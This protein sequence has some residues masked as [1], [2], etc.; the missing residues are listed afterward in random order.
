MEKRK[1]LKKKSSAAMAPKKSVKR[2]SKIKSFG[3]IT[4]LVLGVVLIPSGFVLANYIQGRIDEGVADQ[5][6]VPHPHNSEFEEWES[7]NYEDAPEQYKT[8]Y[9]WNLTN[10][11]EYLQGAT[12]VFE[13][14]GPFVFRMYKY[15]YD[16]RF[17]E[18]KNEV[19]YKEYIDYIQVGGEKISE[20]M[21]TNINPGFLGSVI[22]AGGDTPQLTELMLPILLS[23]V[24]TTFIAELNAIMKDLL[25]PAGMK[26]M[27]SESIT[28]QIKS[29]L[30]SLP[31]NI[32]NLLNWFFDFMN[33]DL[34]EITNA[35]IEASAFIIPIDQVVS[36]M[37]AAMPTA[38][39]ILYEEWANDYYPPVTVNLST[40]ISYLRENLDAEDLYN[41]CDALS[42]QLEDGLFKTI[43][44]W[45]MYIID[46]YD[47]L[48]DD[49]IDLT[50]GLVAKY[51]DVLL[52]LLEGLIGDMV[53]D[54]GAGLVDKNGGPAGVGVDIDG[55][56]PYNFPGAPAD[57][58]ISMHS[59]GGSG[60]TLE[61]SKAL[62]D[63]SDPLSLTGFN[64]R[65]NKIW[66]KALA[67]DSESKTE[68]ISHFG[69]T[70]K[71]LN[72]ILKWINVGV[73]TW[74]K[75]AGGW[76]LNDWNSDLIVTR[77]AEEVLFTGIDTAV[78]KAQ[79]YYGLDLS[80][81]E[82]NI[83]DDC[84]NVEEAEAAETPEITQKTG[85]HDASEVGEI[86][87]Y[88]DQ[89]EITIWA[90]PIDVKGTDGT[91]FGP[92]VTDEDTLK[93]FTKD[94][95][96]TVEFEYHDEAEIYD[97]D[98]LEFKFADDTFAPNS[99]YLMD[100]LGLVNLAPVPKYRDVPVRVS[101]P[102]FLGADPE[103]TQDVEGMN[104]DPALHDTYLE[105]EPITGLTM[106]VRQRIQVNL[107]PMQLTDWSNNAPHAVMPLLWMEDSGQVSEELATYFKEQVYG[108]MELK[109]QV[110]IY[111][112][113]IGACLAV[114]GAGFKTTQT[115]RKRQF[116]DKVLPKKDKLAKP[117][118]GDLIDRLGIGA[119][120]LN[121]GIHKPN[122]DNK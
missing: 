65:E 14:V 82:V 88:N 22:E 121:N 87:D 5:V 109:E 102:H 8:I 54:I 60:I 122:G 26:A 63:K 46:H 7:N 108:A 24:R 56:A 74:A 120:G 89:D 28:S 51:E 99:I 41:F 94:L 45:A 61:Q 49:I 69:I 104:P 6:K 31:K 76:T 15:K 48:V 73:N 75:N 118:V 9:L 95:M 77:S 33:I 97:I 85:R 84:Q 59:R 37:K 62:W 43:L 27:L 96:R 93:V 70:V 80:L 12:P 83:L 44:G 113:G 11:D 98:L 116:K 50:M 112:L 58:N 114:P 2:P 53:R 21:I 16:I 106:K 32:Q 119:Q 107:E 25:T 67:G 117:Q 39:E 4:M 10:A 34:E 90:E 57:L 71:Q 92:G 79:A 40:T 17:S 81:A 29:L 13:Q 64:Y 36:M 78:Y 105:V 23:E 110:P 38:E 19:S 101:K 115:Q 30:N 72:M 111:A 86:V 55:R 42:K 35:V 66:Y 3:A 47:W 91:T 1:D 103:L 20:V 100:T 18:H 68:L 52:P